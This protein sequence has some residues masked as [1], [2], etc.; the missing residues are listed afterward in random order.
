MFDTNGDGFLNAAEIKEVMNNIGENMTDEEVRKYLN[1]LIYKISNILRTFLTDNSPFTFTDPN[2][3]SDPD[4]NPTPVVDSSDW[5]V[6][7]S[8]M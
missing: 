6:P 5:K 4:S 1:S 2:S 7:H 3:D 8:T